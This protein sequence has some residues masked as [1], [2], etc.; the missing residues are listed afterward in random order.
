MQQQ[1]M[2]EPS[3]EHSTVTVRGLLPE[4]MQAVI[5]L[6]AKTTG[7]RREEYFKVKLEQ[8]LVETGIKVSLAAEYD[9]LFAGFLLARVFYGEFGQ[10]EQ[11]A[12]LDTLVAHPDFRRKGIGK[13]LL[14]QLCM[15]LKAL[16]VT[17]LQTEVL[18]DDMDLIRFFHDVGFSP[19]QRLCLDYDL[20]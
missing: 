19:A 20:A 11:V 9:D 2:R 12:V 1:D 13:A 14:E 18:W 4:D 5:A 7:R 16:G 6:D 8:N 15:N 17:R 10:S 3:L